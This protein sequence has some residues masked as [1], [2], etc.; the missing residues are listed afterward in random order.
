MASR[1]ANLLILTHSPHRPSVYPATDMSGR[2]HR[3]SIAL[4]GVLGLIAGACGD[5]GTN[6]GPTDTTA[7]T[8]SCQ[9]GTEYCT[10]LGGSVCEGDLSCVMDYCVTPGSNGT[11]STSGPGSTSGDTADSG[12]TT[13]QSTTGPSSGDTTQGIGST[14]DSGTTT[15][16]AADPFGCDR[17]EYP[18]NVVGGG[19]YD[20]IGA[21]VTAAPPDATVQ[22][23]PGTYVENILV[24]RNLTLLGSGVEDTTIDGGGVASTLYVDGVDL[25][26]AGFTITNGMAH[27]NPLGGAGT[28]GGGLAIEYSNGQ[29]ITID[30]CVFTNNQASLGA[31]IC[32]DG[33]TGSD[34]ADLVLTQVMIH[35]NDASAN[36]AG[37][38]SFSDLELND[39]EIV[40]N[41]AGNHGGG[42]YL[43]YGAATVN[44]GTVRNNV[45]D[46]GGGA[47]LQNPFTLDVIASDWGEGAAL[48]NA[49]DDVGCYVDSF[50]FFGANATFSCSVPQYDQCSCG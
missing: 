34:D 47:Y 41:T 31:A 37:I 19:G 5:D 4:A 46:E 13:A 24:E 36:G 7:E 33:Q 30:D 32:A 50:G 25:T 42:L 49:P 22:V 14:G 12:S 40:D 2:F 43:S 10:C 11:G 20:T 28:C 16:G 35:D 38:F 21:A 23:C 18:V 26:L 27:L 17:L 8:G 3:S 39:C 1:A 48:E 29:L 45:A 6:Q 15:G 9:P 44:G